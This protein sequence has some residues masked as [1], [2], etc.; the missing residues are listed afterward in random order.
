MIA[1]SLAPIVGRRQLLELVRAAI[2]AP[3]GNN[4]QPWRFGVEDHT[5]RLSPEEAATRL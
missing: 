4:S 1:P 3:S 2:L 5:I